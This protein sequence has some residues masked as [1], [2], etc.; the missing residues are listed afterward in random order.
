MNEKAESQPVRVGVIGLGYWGPKL[1]RN[2]HSLPGVEMAM[3]SDLR[4]ERLDDLKRNYV[5]IAL[6]QNYRDLLNDGLDAVVIATPVYTHY[7]LAREALLA[8]KHVFVEKPLTTS[9]AEGVEL[10]ELA[11]QKNLR[12]MVGHTFVYNPGV[13]A[14]KRIIQ[15]GEL[16]SIYY[17]NSTRVNLGLLQPDI[18][19]MW[20]LAPHDLSILSYI[21]DDD[22]VKVSALGSVYVNKSRDLHEV[23][24]INLRYRNDVIANLR[25]SWLDPVKIRRLTVVGSRK[26]LVYDDISDNKVMLYDKGV[27]VPPYSLTEAEFKASYRNGPETVVPYEWVEPLRAECEHFIDCIRTADCPRSDGEK[28]LKVVRILETAQRSLLNGG[29]ELVIEY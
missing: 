7:Q 16:G 17:L 4:K 6:T 9:S 20:D 23:V 1:A 19:V 8:G 2:L 14:V 21:L 29:L 22:P 12:L 15:S 5:D 13:E 24:Y 18:N 11:R 27:D 10:I 26:M 25:V 3:A 28:G